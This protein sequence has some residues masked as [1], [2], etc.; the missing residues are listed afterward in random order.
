MKLGKALVKRNIA[1][2]FWA[3]KR[4]I[5]ILWNKANYLTEVNGNG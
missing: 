2:K 4:V 1:I 5:W 3:L